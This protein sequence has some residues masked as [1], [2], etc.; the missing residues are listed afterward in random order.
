M[1]RH[2]GS[3]IIKAV[4]MVVQDLFAARGIHNTVN[5]KEESKVPVP[6]RQYTKRNIF[7]RDV[8]EALKLINEVCGFLRNKRC[9]KRE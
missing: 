7:P 6:V 4:K 1:N 9:M 3:Q 8:L 5:S 2:M